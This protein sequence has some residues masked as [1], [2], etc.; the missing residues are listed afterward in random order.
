MPRGRATSRRSGRG[1]SSTDIT[2]TQGLASFAAS[3]GFEEEAK[4]ILEKPKLS[5]LQ[6]IGRILNSFE[7]GNAL[8][9]SRYEDKSFTKTFVSD[10]VTELKSGITGREQ[11][12][13]PKKIFKDILVMEGAKD[14]PGKLDVV[15]VAGLAGDILT[16]PTT[17]FGGLLA[18]PI[19]KSAKVGLKVSKKV[20]IAGKYIEAGEEGLAGLFKPF[21]KIEKLGDTGKAYRKGFETY[22]KGTRAEMDDF[23]SEVA[24]KAKAG[25]KIAG[26]KAGKII[27]EVVENPT[28]KTTGNKFLDEIMNSL[29]Q[30]Q[31]KM[32]AREVQL[33]ILEHQ[34]PDYM[35]HMLTA[36][37]SDFIIKG[38]GNVIESYVP[39]VKAKLGAATQRTIE[40]AV[41]DINTD[42][43]EKYGIKLFEE[44]AFKAFAKR[45][46]DSIRSVNSHSFLSRVAEQFGIKAKDNFIDKFGVR[47]VDAPQGLKG[48]RGYKVP[49]AIAQHL[50]ETNRLL[51]DDEATNGLLRLYDKALSYWK[52]S[53]TGYFPAF[54]TRN[55]L[56]GTF[57][58][59]VAGLKDPI[60][61]KKAH[62]IVEGKAGKITLKG[63]EYTYDSIR[64]LLKEY[65]VVGQTGYLD[66][67]KF[68]TRE[69]SPTVASRVTKLPQQVMGKVEDRLRT[70][71]FLDGL[72]KGLDP[73]DAAK[74]VIKYHFDY[75][76]EGFTAFEKNVMKRVIPFY[77]WTRH[78][79]PLQLE[80][81]IM[82]PGKYAGVFKTQRAWGAKPSSEEEAIL[83]R[84]LKERYTIKGEGGYWSGLGLPLEEATDK[85]SQPFR[86]FG[87][88]M[89]PFI[90]VPIE[91]LTGYN[92][93]KE[94]RIDEDYFARQYKNIPEP[95]KKWLEMKE[96]KG[97]DGKTYY[98]IN[99]KKRYW[100]ETVGARGWNTALSVANATDDKKNLLSLITT[101]KKYKYSLEELISWSDRN[102]KK[103]L[104]DALK[105][106]GEISEFTRLYVPK[107]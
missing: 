18:K 28:T 10:V 12:L 97:K 73:T 47:W 50:A 58:N 98:T 45:G 9:R 76:P 75:M 81:M 64:K 63:K 44:D 51:F 11:R 42:F 7:T 30:T 22:V 69:V 82:Q 94:K 95:M 36:D 39:S 55:A 85:L 20:P 34:L 2:T 4:K 17:F 40:G 13:T 103:E 33:G 21:H 57:N 23:L 48:L 102:K 53:V 86:G 80:Q 74:R 68:L 106:A 61:Y 35:H 93:F 101:I 72:K 79:I 100:L 104:E 71:L 37:A 31:K 88:S 46:L 3:R 5:L 96:F 43:L 6:R 89:S 70:P 78:N 24:S 49:K 52:G 1:G 59:W 14:R 60:L 65:G 84:W 32:T 8:Y 26:K 25:K 77:T 92:I 105:A 56:G 83:P 87:I 41:A 27:G 29:V 107:K 99:P 19:K 91:Q 67:R 16:D 90:R 66:V 62:D 38:G 54:H 15:D